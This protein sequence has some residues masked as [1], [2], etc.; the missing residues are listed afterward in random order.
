MGKQ[1]PISTMRRRV[2]DGL[3][4]GQDLLPGPRLRTRDGNRAKGDDS[5][6]ACRDCA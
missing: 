6:G 5:T 4:G 3:D 1:A 2:V